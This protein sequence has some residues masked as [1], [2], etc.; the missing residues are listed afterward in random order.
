M[1]SFPVCVFLET[2]GSRREKQNPPENPAGFRKR[3]YNLSRS[4]I[5]PEHNEMPRNT[6][7]CGGGVQRL[8][9][10]Y[11]HFGQMLR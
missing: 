10:F 6:L 1:Y 9:R 3:V 8:D 11:E 4:E 2:H 7:Q 5:P